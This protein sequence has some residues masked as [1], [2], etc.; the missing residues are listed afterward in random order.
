MEDTQGPG[1]GGSAEIRGESED[2]QKF[3]QHGTAAALTDMVES[4]RRAQTQK[5]ARGICGVGGWGG[6]GS[7][8]DTRNCSVEMKGCWTTTP[9]KNTASWRDV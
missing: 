8:E 4:Y 2:K 1:G 3:L 5:S 9:N 7:A 6:W